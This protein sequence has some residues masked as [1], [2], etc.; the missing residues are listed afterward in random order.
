MHAVRTGRLAVTI[1][2]VRAAHGAIRDAIVRTPISRS[3]TLSAITGADV[4]IK[5]ENLQYTASF[6][7][8]G[9]RN[10]LL[11][12]EPGQAA[13]GVVAMSAGNH[14]QA[15]AHHAT[16]LGIRSTVVMPVGTPATKISATEDN[17]ARVVVAGVPTGITTVDRM[18]S[19]VAW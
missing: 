1:D 12:L 2:D 19:S 14:A 16:L 7:E 11:Q 13:A 3:Q 18:P 4:W 6:K 10:R 8:R 9:A 15:V 17:G 5:F